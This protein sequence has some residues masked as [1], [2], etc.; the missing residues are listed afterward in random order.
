MQSLEALDTL[1]KTVS[2]SYS[3]AYKYENFVSVQ[4]DKTIKNFTDRIKKQFEVTYTKPIE[5]STSEMKELKLLIID[6]LKNKKNNFNSHY[7]Q[8]LAWH[9]DDMKVMNQKTKFAERSVS[10]LE[11]APNPLLPFTVTNKIFQLFEKTNIE[12]EKV[13]TA[14]LLNYLNNYEKASTRF[15]NVL[16]RYLKS[17]KYIKDVDI[18]FNFITLGQFLTKKRIEYKKIGDGEKFLRS[19]LELS[20]VN[21]VLLETKYF[22]DALKQTDDGERINYGA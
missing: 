13:S 22:N 10:F 11:Y 18:F 14:L 1:A 2:S 7:I 19:L 16:R 21:P 6:F 20:G 12:P 17:I 8:L 3:F 9:I 4:T 15:K 5:M